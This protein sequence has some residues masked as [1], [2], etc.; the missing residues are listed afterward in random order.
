MSDELQ[1]TETAGGSQSRRYTGRRTPSRLT[2]VFDRYESPLYFVTLCTAERRKTLANEEVHAAFKEFAEKGRERGIAVGRYVIMPDH[3]HLFVAG[4]REFD[5][6]TWVRLLKSALGMPAGA[7]QRGFF[8][9]LLRH[10][11]SYGEKWDYVRQNPMRAGLV[12]RAEDWP[13]QGEVVA[14]DRA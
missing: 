9:H 3:V 2:T 14:I 1:Q 11:E 10:D 6:G 8:D 7:W 5:L 13:H 12:R 4:G